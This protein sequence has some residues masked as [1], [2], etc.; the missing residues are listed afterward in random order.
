MNKTD[1]EYQQ[2][3]HDRLFAFPAS[4]TCT[5]FN[6]TVTHNV[7]LEPAEKVAKKVAK[8][9]ARKVAKIVA[10][11]VAKKVAEKV[12]KMKKKITIFARHLGATVDLQEF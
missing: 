8:K 6:F 4:T 9:V 3:H 2:N 11:K 7:Q 10:K 12:A 5:N 1:A